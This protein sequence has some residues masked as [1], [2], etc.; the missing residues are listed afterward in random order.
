MQICSEHVGTLV[1]QSYDKPSAGSTR[2]GAAA[3]LAPTSRAAGIT[4][5]HTS[6]ARW[7]ARHRRSGRHSVVCVRGAATSPAPRRRATPHR[8]SGISAR[9]WR[10]LRRGTECVAAAAASQA[11]GPSG[12]AV[13][14]AARLRSGGPWR[15]N[16]PSASWA[17]QQANRQTA[18]GACSAATRRRR[19]PRRRSGSKPSSG[20]RQAVRQQASAAWHQASA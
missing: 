2:R 20:T 13:T 18:I 3:S 15:G 7:Q 4:V 12:A 6:R 9:P 5:P 11:P 19:T 1:E 8:R 17:W 10:N 14:K 16:K